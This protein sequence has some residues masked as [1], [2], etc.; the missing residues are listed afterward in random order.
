MGGYVLV[1]SAS[2]RRDLRKIDTDARERI[3]NSLDHLRE[4]PLIGKKLSAVKIGKWR[5][6]IGDYRV[7]YDIEGNSIFLYRVR[8]RRES[9]RD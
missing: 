1:P 3:L 5:I 8:H 9:Y 4:N 7:R 6:R 2:F